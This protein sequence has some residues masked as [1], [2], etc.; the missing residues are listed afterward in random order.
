MENL[1]KVLGSADSSSNAD[2]NAMAALTAV[3][4]IL[5]ALIERDAIDRDFVCEAL[6]D[7]VARHKH[8]ATNGSEKVHRRAASAIE[9]MIA[10][11]QAT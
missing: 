6:G 11:C 8:A 7:A 9:V 1:M 5:I 10:D 4:V 2:A 3:E